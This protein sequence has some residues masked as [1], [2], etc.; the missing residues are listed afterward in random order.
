[1]NKIPPILKGLFASKIRIKLLEY[2]LSHSND[3][4]Y[5]RQ[6]EKLLGEPA[7]PLGRELLSLAKI[8]ILKSRKVG[9]QKHYHVK[10]DM[11]FFTDLRRLF[12]KATIGNVIKKRLFATKGI[13][14]AFIYGSLAKSE[15]HQDSDVDIM[16][17]GDVTDEE[18]NQA[19]SSVEKKQKRTI[20][21][22]LY[23]R[24]EVKERLQK[25]DDFISTVFSEPHI[26]ILGSENDGLFQAGQ[27]Q[28]Y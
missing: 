14:L 13:E 3:S 22:S 25:K 12:L 18:V 1:M 5:L 24:K 6:L 11:M 7:G 23:G 2:F 17:I 4:F 10:K 27:S 20:N 9:N 15:E 19:I 16:V 8:G 26:I 21:Y 28:T